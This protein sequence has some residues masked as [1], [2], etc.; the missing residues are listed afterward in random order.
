MFNPL[1]ASSHQYRLQYQWRLHT[2]GLTWRGLTSI[3]AEVLYICHT[4]PQLLMWGIAHSRCP[5][6]IAA[7]VLY[8]VATLT[9]LQLLL[10]GRLEGVKSTSCCVKCVVGVVCLAEMEIHFYPPCSSLPLLSSFSPIL[11][12]NIFSFHFF[13][14]TV[15]VR[16]HIYCRHLDTG[17]RCAFA[18]QCIFSW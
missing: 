10:Q 14:T 3:A 11:N 7:K 16:F 2:R 9:L 15:L 13:L 5:A 18:I 4:L 8:S 12:R 17:V 6:S 1:C